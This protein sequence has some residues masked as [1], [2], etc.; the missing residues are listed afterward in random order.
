[1]KIKVN[2]DVTE[3]KAGTVEA[4]LSELNLRREGVAV[5]VNLA[6]VKKKDYAGF[7]LKEG[8]EVEIV[9]LVGGG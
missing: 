1:M 7:A 8:D 4:L 6:I 3:T 2:G 5:E 9:N